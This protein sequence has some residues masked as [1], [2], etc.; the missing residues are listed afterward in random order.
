MSDTQ[1]ARRIAAFA[2]IYLIWGSTYLAIAV[3]VR[4]IPPFLL[5]GSRSLISGA[6]LLGLSRAQSSAWPPARAWPSAAVG[7]ILLFGGCHGLLAYAERSVTSGLAAM[8]LA[9]IP[10]WIILIKWATPGGE[11]PGTAMLAALVPGLVGVALCAIRFDGSGAMLVAPTSL[12]MLIGAALSWAAGSVLSQKHAALTSATALAGM[13]LL[14][15]G[16]ILGLASLLTGEIIG[17]SAAQVAPQS[18]AAFGYLTLIGSVVAF[19]AYVWLLDNA[20]APL[21]AT[22]T[23]VNPFVAVALGWA[24]LG[25]RLTPSMLPGFLLVICSVVAVWY[26]GGSGPSSRTRAGS[27]GQASRTARTSAVATK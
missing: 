12:L 24:V 3:G 16:A 2:A 14:S 11:R 27:F 17:F 13:Q 21:V 18:W 10:F 1:K 9:T 19:T 20:P 5:I 15:G 7:G 26:F 4:S 6:L 22:Y 23:F 8:M 25:E